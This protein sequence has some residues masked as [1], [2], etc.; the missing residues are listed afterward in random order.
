[1]LHL[2]ALCEVLDVSLDDAVRGVP[3]EART[4]EEQVMLDTFRA[5]GD[6]GRELL[7]AMGRQM[8]KPGK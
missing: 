7:L 3:T 1:M 8:G 5:L 2:K 4:A 6:E